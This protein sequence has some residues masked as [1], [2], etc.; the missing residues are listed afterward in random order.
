MQ[1]EENKKKQSERMKGL[2]EKAQ[3]EKEKTK[4]VYV[5]S[6]QISTPPEKPE[7]ENK[8][9]TSN[10]TPEEMAIARRVSSEDR[11]WETLVEGEVNDYSLSEDPFKLPPPAQ[12]LRDKREF[13]FRWITRDPSRI[14]EVKGKRRPLQWWVVTRTNPRANI[15]DKYIDPICGGI[16]R[17][18]QI[19][20]FKPYWLFEE[21]LN[22]KRGLSDSMT[23]SK[24][25]DNKSKEQDGVELVGS[26]TIG[27]SRLS[28]N[29]GDI[30]YAGEAEADAAS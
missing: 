11:S 24:D 18:D 17:E 9:D 1:T 30:S 14:D 20:V 22:F 13:A 8:I 2:W 21:E 15:F 19:L 16:I 25:L 26:R 10:L 27:K 6:E 12:E 7:A 4:V 28:V 29:S 5:Q 3:E 23:Q